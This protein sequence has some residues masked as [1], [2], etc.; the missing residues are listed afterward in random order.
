MKLTTFLNNHYEEFP[1]VCAVI[2]FKPSKTTGAQQAVSERRTIVE[3]SFFAGTIKIM[4]IDNGYKKEYSYGDKEYESFRKFAWKCVFSSKVLAVTFIIPEYFKSAKREEFEKMYGLCSVRNIPVDIICN[5]RKFKSTKE[6]AV[7]LQE[8]RTSIEEFSVS[9]ECVSLIIKHA[10]ELLPYLKKGADVLIEVLRQ[11][12][13]LSGYDVDMQSI[14]TT[15]GLNHGKIDDSKGQR[16]WSRDYT[17]HYERYQQN[18]IDLLNMYISCKFY[19][20]AGFEVET[21]GIGRRDTDS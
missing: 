9:V 3:I 16:E 14:Y 2:G 18:L 4:R 19:K 8:R 20:Q 13:K 15:D 7:Y 11:Q 6:H 17:K 12:I 10:K 1:Q 5:G 21:D